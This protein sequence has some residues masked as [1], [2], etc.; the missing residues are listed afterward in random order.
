MKSIILGDGNDSVTSERDCG[1]STPVR[2][3]VSEY[4]YPINARFWQNEIIWL[5]AAKSTK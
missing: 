1:P 2:I 5:L 3:V 4:L